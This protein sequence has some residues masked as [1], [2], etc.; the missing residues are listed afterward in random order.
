MTIDTGDRFGELGERYGHRVL[1]ALLDVEAVLTRGGELVSRGRAWFEHDPAE[2]PQ[3]AAE[4]LVARLAHAVE[5]LPT[6]FVEEHPEIPWRAVGDAHDR[7]RSG[8]GAPERLW[9]VLSH[10]FVELQAQITT[11]LTRV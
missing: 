8:A 11:L 4:A 6:R 7:L 9:H 5:A 3:L 1:Q 10:D 2:V